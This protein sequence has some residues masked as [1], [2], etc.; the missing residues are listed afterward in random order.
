MGYIIGTAVLSGAA[1]AMPQSEALSVAAALAVLNPVIDRIRQPMHAVVDRLPMLNRLSSLVGSNFA[2]AASAVALSTGLNMISPSADGGYNQRHP[3][4]FT[5]A[6]IGLHETYQ[7]TVKPVFSFL[8][9]TGDVIKA[10]ASG[11]INVFEWA[12]DSDLTADTGQFARSVDYLEHYVAD[13]IETIISPY[14]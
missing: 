12:T 8:D 4:F 10:P 11:I 9:G 2:M 14:E 1:A 7:G 3:D 5:S 13:G 6:Q